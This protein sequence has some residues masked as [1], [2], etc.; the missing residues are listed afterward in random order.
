[1]RELYVKP[2]LRGQSIRLIEQIVHHHVSARAFVDAVERETGGMP[3]RLVEALARSV[4][5]GAWQPGG[6]GYRFDSGVFMPDE[7]AATR[8]LLESFEDEELGFRQFLLEV[9]TSLLAGAVLR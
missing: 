2:F 3:R 9:D 5:Q 7:V 1:M 8:R 4:D 6:A